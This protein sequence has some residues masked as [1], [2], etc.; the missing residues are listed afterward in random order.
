MLILHSEL[1]PA[2][3]ILMQGHSAHHTFYWPH[4]WSAALLHLSPED[5]QGLQERCDC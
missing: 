4:F 5:F 3:D 2:E 1:M